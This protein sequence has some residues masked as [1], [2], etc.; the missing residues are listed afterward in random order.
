MN[1]YIN[2]IDFGYVVI[3]KN[4]TEGIEL[5]IID[6][7]SDKDIEQYASI[8]RDLTTNQPFAV[9]LDENLKEIH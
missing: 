9:L 1:R 7:V 2:T 8:R 5:T 6:I 4:F 3:R